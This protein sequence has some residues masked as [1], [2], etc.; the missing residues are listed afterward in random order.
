MLLSSSILLKISIKPAT[1]NRSM[2]SIVAGSRSSFGFS[3]R[4]FGDSPTSTSSSAASS[5]PLDF[6]QPEQQKDVNEQA[7]SAEN[8]DEP[9]WQISDYARR[10][11]EKYSQSEHTDIS[12]FVNVL[13]KT[14]QKRQIV[15]QHIMQGMHMLQQRTNQN[16]DELFRKCIEMLSP[17]LDIGSFKRGSKQIRVP[18][19]V[20]EK[21]GR[22]NAFR[23][24]S[25]AVR[26]N[27][28]GQNKL[29]LEERFVKEVLAV[30]EGKSSLLQR[31]ANMHRE[32][33]VNRSFA[34]HRWPVGYS[35]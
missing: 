23:W 27:G 13:M 16:P 11:A 5:P 14:G 3:R 2:A 29:P 20:T 30:L 32:A 6:L 33:L 22:G 25:G 26:K 9:E 17:S 24:L 7:H 34:Q 19:P 4:S 15:E 1:F 8:E 12:E 31:K 35:F 10:Q 28:A 21:R 18:L